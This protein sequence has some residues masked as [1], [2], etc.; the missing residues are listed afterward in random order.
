MLFLIQFDGWPPRVNDGVALMLL[1]LVEQRE[2][3]GEDQ[4]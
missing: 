1:L 4:G 2:E 3:S